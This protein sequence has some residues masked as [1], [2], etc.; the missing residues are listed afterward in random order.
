MTAEVHLRVQY[1]ER[2]GRVWLHCS[3]SQI[4]G[5]KVGTQLTADIECPASWVPTNPEELVA[6]LLR[7]GHQMAYG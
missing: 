7:A 4:G 3:M 1:I 6:L 2:R 5:G